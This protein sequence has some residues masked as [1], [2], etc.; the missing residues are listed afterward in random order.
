[1]STLSTSARASLFLWDSRRHVMLKSPLTWSPCLEEAPVSWRVYPDLLICNLNRE[2]SSLRAILRLTGNLLS[3]RPRE[4]RVSP[5]PHNISQ[6]SVSHCFLFS[7]LEGHCSEAM[8]FVYDLSS[9][10]VSAADWVGPGKVMCLPSWYLYL[11]ISQM[12]PREADVQILVSSRHLR[13]RHY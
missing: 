6:A 10:P 5:S 12:L 9:S 8:L 1:M 11:L 7:H 2:I 13:L 4:S 3:P